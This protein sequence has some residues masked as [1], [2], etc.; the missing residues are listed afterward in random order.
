MMPNAD[1]AVI[2]VDKISDYLLSRSHP[3]G[4]RKAAFFRSFGFDDTTPDVLRDALLAHAQA[5]AV[6]R[7]VEGVHGTKYEISGPL[8]TP[9]GKLPWLKTVWI[10]IGDAPPRLITAVPVRGST[11]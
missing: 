10:T 7:R 2:T 11:Q 8:V 6:S 3:I 9:S 4:S 5:Y 1:R